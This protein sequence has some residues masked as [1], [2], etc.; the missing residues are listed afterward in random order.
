MADPPDG[1]GVALRA[2]TVALLIAIFALPG[3]AVPSSAEEEPVISIGDFWTYATNTTATEGFY[4]IG[5]ITFTIAG[6][7]TITIEGSPVE[8]FRV[9]VGGEGVAMGTIETAFGHVAAT[10]SWR[11]VGEEA[12]AI[13]GLKIVSSVLDLRANGTLHTDP[14]AQRF[15]LRF[16][17]TTTFDILEDT[18]RFP[19]DVGDSGLVRA[20]ANWTEDVAIQYGFVSDASRTSGRAIRRIDFLAEAR[21]TVQTPL[22]PFSALRLREIWPDGSHELLFFSS[23]VGNNVRTEAYDANGRLVGSTN[24][25]SYR[26]Q[27][28]EPVTALG[29]TYLQWSIVAAVAAGASATIA[30]VWRRRRRASPPALGPPTSGP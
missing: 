27:A 1:N 12:L 30:I 24:L 15:A 2:G 18:W 23:D 22:G 29:L 14:I 6:R 9:S 8:V 21:E 25:E 10:G 28:R 7:A 11:I 4:L 3:V 17:N 19:V 26:Y 13:D 5:P 16:Q 20:E